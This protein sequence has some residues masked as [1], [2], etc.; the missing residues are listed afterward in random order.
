[1]SV[2]KNKNHFILHSF[3]GQE[4]GKGSAEQVC[5]GVSPVVTVRHQAGCSLLGT[6]L[7]WVFKMAH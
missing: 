1:M 7:G 6:Q 5:L 3:V 2:A 4:F